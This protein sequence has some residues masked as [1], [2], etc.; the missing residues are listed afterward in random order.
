[1]GLMVIGLATRLYNFLTG[2]RRPEIDVHLHW[3]RESR[4]WSERKIA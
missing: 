2:S 4:A 3:D 1:M